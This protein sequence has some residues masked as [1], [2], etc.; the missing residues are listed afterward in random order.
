M[1]DTSHRFATRALH[2]GWHHDPTTGAFGVPIYPTAAF[3]FESSDHA[4]SLF[5]LET[6]GHIYS[7]LSNPSVSIFEERMSSL[8]NGVGSV[9]T[10]S[11]QAAAAHLVMTLCNAGDNVVAGKNLYGGTLTLLRNLFTRFGVATRLVNT[12]APAEVEEAMDGKTRAL[13]TETLGNP[14]LNVAPLEQLVDVSR[15]R[16]V[17]L[18][19]D[20]TFASPALCRPLEWGASAVFHS[21]TKYLSGQGSVL[22][23]VVVDGGNFDWSD[24]RWPQFSAPD[25]A[26]HGV[27][28]SETFGRGA[29]AARLR[30][31]TLRDLGGCLSPFNAYL[32]TLGLTTLELRMRRHSETALFLAEF[33]EAHPA[34]AWVRYPGL[35]SHPQFIFARRYL[36]P[37]CGGMMAFCLRGGREVGKRFVEHLELFGHVANVGDVRSLVVHPA[38][39]THAQLSEA[40]RAAAGVEEGL[41]R[42]SIGLEDPEDLRADLAR[43]LQAAVQGA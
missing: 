32:L 14:V 20:N 36:V 38:S 27:V 9:A 18:V 4:A 2:A 5:S 13:F 21:A 30:C 7:R 11:G 42:L 33:L 43:A 22:G 10:A 25:P 16:R 40:E 23:G 8:E 29:L 6:P 26:Y 28:F 35:H 34:V 12:D 39:T 37:G 1:D 31:H 41:I 24:G 19:V 15:R 3:Q 17:P